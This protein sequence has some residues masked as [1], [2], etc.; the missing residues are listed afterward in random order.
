MTKYV[1][2]NGA[3][4][5]RRFAPL[6]AV[7][8]A[9]VMTVAVVMPA[10]VPS[11]HAQF[12]NDGDV[13]I[14]PQNTTPLPFFNIFGGGQRQQQRTQEQQREADEERMRLEAEARAAAAANQRDRMGTQGERPTGAH[15]TYLVIGDSLAA[16]LAEGLIDIHASDRAF[17]I[18]DRSVAFSGLFAQEEH[19]WARELRQILR[20]ENP[21]AI[22]VMLG[23]NDRL[24]VPGENNTS[25]SVNS[26]GWQTEYINRVD[27]LLAVL[28]ERRIP[29]IWVG[30]PPVASQSAARDFS[31]FNA[32]YR[33]RVEAAGFFFLDIWDGFADANGQYAAQGPNVEGEIV[34]LR[35]DDGIH[36]RN[37][38]KKKLAFF[39]ERLRR[40]LLGTSGAGALSGIAPLD[41]DANSNRRRVVLTGIAN[42]PGAILSGGPEARIPSP[43]TE[44]GSALPSGQNSLANEVMR[45][46]PL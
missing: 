42:R 21:R 5:K 23:V 3:R 39:A 19:D 43:F 22:F 12:S 7:L 8:I 33:Q 6:F 13:W 38:G 46:N 40:R 34:A 2:H 35:E 41:V 28:V 31:R 26:P 17:W 10:S 24:A 15:D 29:V 32:I 1:G 25:L 16:Q 44:D 36:F 30:L 37:Q 45:R 27:G 11:A 18:E 20:E 14:P 9:A 4:P